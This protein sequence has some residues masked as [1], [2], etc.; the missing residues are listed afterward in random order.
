MIF[1]IHSEYGW[2][3]QDADRNIMVKG[4]KQLLP[5]RVST[6]TLDEESSLRRGSSVDEVVR[7]GYSEIEPE[8]VE[9]LRETLNLSYV[10]AAFNLQ[11]KFGPQRWM[12][13]FLDLTRRDAVF[14]LASEIQVQP[15]ALGA[16]HNRLSRL[17]RF[18]FLV[19]KTDSDAAARIIEH[20]ERGQHVVLEFGRYGNDLTA[21]I[22]ASN[23]T[24]EAHPRPVR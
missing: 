24:F 2:N 19:D 7:I 3:G 11:Q 18:G 16:L 8:D 1:D 4:L 15:H 9:L 6:F 20:L 21:Y 5:S 10:A 22:L 23:L 12:K 14:E 13:E 17:K